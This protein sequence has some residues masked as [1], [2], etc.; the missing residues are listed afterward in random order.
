ML[1]MTEE[2]YKNFSKESICKESRYESELKAYLDEQFNK[3]DQLISI[4]SKENFWELIPEILGVDAKISLIIEMSRIEDF[5]KN[6][7]IRI[8]ENDYRGYFKE[9]CGY[10]LNMETGS[11]LIFNVL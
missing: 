2:E 5:S 11:S 1:P 9:L 10:T 4:I 6:E 7:I 3:L 8:T